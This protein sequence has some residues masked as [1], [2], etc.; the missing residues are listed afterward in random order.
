MVF[1]WAAEY[2]GKCT[3][4]E[5]I[6]CTRKSNLWEIG[7]KNSLLWE[8][9]FRAEQVNQFPQ[10]GDLANKYT[11]LTGN[12]PTTAFWKVEFKQLQ[13]MEFDKIVGFQ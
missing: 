13:Y 12:L 9:S 7:K 4:S 11:F 1:C 5:F 3:C 8:S 10:Y 6:S 2:P